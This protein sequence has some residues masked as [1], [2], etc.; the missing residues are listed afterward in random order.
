MTGKSQAKTKCKTL[1]WYP[2]NSEKRGTQD[3]YFSFTSSICSYTH[4]GRLK[5]VE[6]DNKKGA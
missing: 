6:A 3:D 1:K 5:Q 2:W 4:S